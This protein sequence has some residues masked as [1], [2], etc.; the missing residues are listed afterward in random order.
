NARA[1]P[2]ASRPA[3]AG[4]GCRA[5]PGAPRPCAPARRRYR[6]PW[7]RASAHAFALGTASLLARAGGAAAAV[8][9]HVGHV[10]AGIRACTATLAGVLELVLDIGAFALAL[11][12]A[13]G[14]HAFV[15]GGGVAAL[16]WDLAGVLVGRIGHVVLLWRGGLE[17]YPATHEEHALR[18]QSRTT[19]L[20]KKGP[21]EAGPP[22]TNLRRCDQ[23][24]GIGSGSGCDA[25]LRAPRL[26]RCDSS[27]FSASMPSPRPETLSTA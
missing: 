1:A 17:N 24:A 10:A 12:V 11:G 18:L 21:A 16:G 6:Q 23:P 5:R 25:A 27:R 19:A 22:R 14:R 26:K 3:R 2:R 20:T 9:I 7:R 8:A 13:L 15:V 4:R